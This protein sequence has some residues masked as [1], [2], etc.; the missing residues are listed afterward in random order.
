MCISIMCISVQCVIL[1]EI[2]TGTSRSK[3]DAR[4]TAFL[5]CQPVVWVPFPYCGLYCYSLVYCV[6]IVMSYAPHDYFIMRKQNKNQSRVT[7]IMN[8][9]VALVF[10][11]F[12]SIWNNEHFSRCFRVCARARLCI[13]FPDCTLCTKQFSSL[14]HRSKKW[15][16]FDWRMCG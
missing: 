15:W 12:V 2:N 16:T 11:S 13:C 3:V 6:L 8:R 10:L 14:V 4:S 5:S 7:E 1:N 9:T